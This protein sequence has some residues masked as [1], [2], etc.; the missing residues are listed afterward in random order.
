MTSESLWDLCKDEIDGVDDNALQSKSVAI[1]L[2]YLRNFWRSLDLPLIN[3]E[4]ELDF[5][6][7]KDC[8]L[9]EHHNSI[10][11]VNFMITSTKLYAPVV[12]VSI[13]DN[14]TFLCS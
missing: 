11:G 1:P 2:K 12:T 9:V 4:V 8:V 6:W 13:N 5:F 14:M 3:F 7:T 10:T